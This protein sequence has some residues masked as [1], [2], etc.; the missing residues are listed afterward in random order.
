M[1]GRGE[2]STPYDRRPAAKRAR[3]RC[4]ALI[5]LLGGWLMPHCGALC[6]AAPP[7]PSCHAGVEAGAIAHAPAR[8]HAHSDLDLDQVGA[9]FDRAHLGRAPLP[10]SPDTGCCCSAVSPAESAATVVSVEL[11]L[12]TKLL[13]AHVAAIADAPLRRGG[14][15]CGAS[16]RT[17]EPPPRPFARTR[18]PLLV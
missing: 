10:T 5:V 11:E 13:A 15:V 6:A 4:A 2:T 17:R 12:R 3:V 14:E 1:I 18:A 16:L 9:M 7:E 8:R